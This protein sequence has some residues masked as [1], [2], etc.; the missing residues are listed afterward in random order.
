LKELDLLFFCVKI[1]KEGRLFVFEYKN[2]VYKK[3]EEM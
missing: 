3:L 1:G 2:K